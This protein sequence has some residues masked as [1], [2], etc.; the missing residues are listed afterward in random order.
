MYI[1]I[2]GGCDGVEG[3][4]SPANVFCLPVLYDFVDFHIWEDIQIL[5]KMSIGH[6]DSRIRPADIHIYMY[7]YIY[8]YRKGYI[9]IYIYEP[10]TFWV[11]APGNFIIYHKHTGKLLLYTHYIYTW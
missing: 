5:G 8:T 1:Y 11:N 9:Y 3:W 4:F 10:D 2:Y 6:G 7:I